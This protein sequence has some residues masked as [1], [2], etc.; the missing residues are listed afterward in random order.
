[1]STGRLAEPAASFSARRPGRVV[2]SKTCI[3]RRISSRFSPVTGAT[4][5]RVE[6]AIRLNGAFVRVATVTAGSFT[7]P[8]GRVGSWYRV[9]AVDAH[10]RVSDASTAVEAAPR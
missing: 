5:Y 3:P 1:M 6:S 8:A 10:A 4:S 7:D 2:W 9:R